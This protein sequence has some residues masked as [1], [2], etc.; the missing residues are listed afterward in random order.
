M[1]SMY[2]QYQFLSTGGAIGDALFFFCSGFTLFLGRIDRFDNWYKRRI[3]RIYP[4]VIAWAIIRAFCGLSSLNFRE[5]IIYGGGWFVSCIMIHYIVLYFIRKFLSDK[6]KLVFCF[7]CLIVGV[8]YLFQDRSG[9]YSIYGGNGYH[10]FRWCFFF[11]FTLFGAIIGT[12]ENEILSQ[13]RNIGYLLISI[14]IYYGILFIGRRNVLMSELQIVSI[15]PLLLI[16]YYFYKFCNLNILKKLY[17][18]KYVGLIMNIISVLTLEI[19]I[20][21]HTM[22]YK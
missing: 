7:V 2:A 12:I 15:V 5:I 20:V 11:V 13:K 16:T 14:F 18:T 9:N 10:Y 6:T 1:D 21:Q 19:Y 3:N 8:L 17:Q 4:S 22:Y